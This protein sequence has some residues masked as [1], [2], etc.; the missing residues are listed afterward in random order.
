MYQYH[1]HYINGQWQDANSAQTIAVI[2]PANGEQIAVVAAAD[3][4]DI[5]SAIAAAKAALPSWSNSSASMRAELI[6]QIADKMQARLAELT[7][8][9]SQSMGCPRHFAEQVQVQSAIDAFRSFADLT[10]VVATQE[11]VNGTI[12]AYSPIGVCVLINPWNY[13]LSQLVGKLGPALAAGCT[14]VVKP[15]EQTPIQDLLLADIFTEVAAP[16]GIF[17]V[18]TGVGNDIGAYLCAHPDVS[19]VS[20]TGSTAAGVKVAEAAAG[21]VKRVCQELGGKSPYIITE[22]ADLAAAVKYGVQDVMFNSGQTCCALTRMLVHESRYEEAVSLAKQVAEANVIGS[23]N[24]P[25]TTMGPLSSKLQQQRVRDY[26]NRGIAEGARLVTGGIDLPESLSEGAYVLP[27]IFADVENHMAI[28]R[29]EI[30]GPVLCIMSYKDIQQA[31]AIAND[32]EY[33]LSS[34]VY[35]KDTESAVNI[36]RQIQAGQCYVQ[37]SYFNSDAPFGGFKQSGNGR[38]WGMEGLREYL[39]VQAVI[40]Q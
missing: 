32:T 31:V 26:I 9:I 35:A 37:G 28:A 22:D 10:H 33:G 6:N 17:N 21:S 38:E 27:T 39:E 18:I 12:H 40:T 20:F 1:S 5:D 15:A 8:V 4:N 13:P 34:G 29:E 16:R 30:F 24:D 23:P 7:D 14:V 25:D 3:N 11:M 36:G 2:N 19:M